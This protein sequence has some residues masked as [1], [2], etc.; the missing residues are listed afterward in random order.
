MERS[1]ANGAPPIVAI[2]GPTATGKTAV[3]MIV[4]AAVSG[5]IISAD[6]MAVYRGMDVGTAKP[7]AAQRALAPFHLLDVADPD[8][9]FT[10]GRFVGLA[11]SALR[12][13]RARGN[14]PL[15]V[16]GT[17]LYI[18]ALLEDFGLTATPANQEVR[19]RLELQAAESGTQFLHNRLAGLDPAAAARIHENDLKRIV[20]ALEV[21]E[22]SGGRLSDRHNLDAQL[23]QRRGARK[24]V[25][26]A[27][28]DELYE[29]IDARVD[30]MI[31][32]GL[33]K[34]VVALMARGY[35]TAHSP[36][37][38]IGYKEMIA[39]LNG[40]TDLEAAIQAIKQNTRRF[41]K[42]QLTWF[43]TE[44]DATWID[45]AGKAPA[46]VAG[47]ILEHLGEE[48]NCVHS[49]PLFGGRELNE[50]TPT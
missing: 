24:F 50:Q 11:K 10:V 43:R 38:S 20:R 17:G 22:V 18:R 13:I 46:E 4:A 6:S 34:E 31:G 36:L 3:A 25:L 40:E 2:M 19:R 42:R 7:T 32:G 45:V 12:D 49:V 26:H 35:S 16:G 28:R 23:R 5:E 39:Y 1:E 8:E 47:T 15:V 37:R 29:R 44:P 30:S 41:A 9:Q 14:R 48:P 21:I 33:E 27:A